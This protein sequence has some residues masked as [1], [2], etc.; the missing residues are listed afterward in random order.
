M[1]RGKSAKGTEKNYIVTDEVPYYISNPNNEPTLRLYAPE[2]LRDRVV[3]RYHDDNGHMGIDKT[4]DAI[5]QKYFWPNIHKHLYEYI[6]S[7]ATCQTRSMKKI[8]PILQE[9]DVP[10]YPFAK[11]GLDLSGPYP[12]TISRNKY[13]IGF[14]DLYSGW[15]EAFAVPDKSGDNIAHLIIK[16]SFPGSVLHYKLLALK[17]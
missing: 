8:K 16:K 17:M 13:I 12:T 4:F 11:I 2:H 9:T 6:S 14:I 3:K 10:P 1:S 15:P 5:R 7:C